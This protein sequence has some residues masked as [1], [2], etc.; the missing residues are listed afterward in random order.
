MRNTGTLQAI[1]AAAVLI[2]GCGSLLQ[3]AGY[4]PEALRNSPPPGIETT[5]L[6]VGAV[7]PD[8]TLTDTDGVKR[9]LGGASERLRVVAFFRGSW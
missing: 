9:K 2:L 5:A 3:I 4:P 6:Q 1:V 8:L 7:A